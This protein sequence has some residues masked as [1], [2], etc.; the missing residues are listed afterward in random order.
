MRLYLQKF[1]SAQQGKT[2]LDQ[3]IQ[4]MPDGN[5]RI[6]IRKARN[7]KS[8]EQRGWLW[9][10]IYPVLLDAMVDAG[11]EI[12]TI[13]E[14]HEFFKKLFASHKVINRFTGE[15]I[16]IPDST[17]EMDTSEYSAYCEKLRE[18]AWE[19]LNVEIPDPDRNWKLTDR[20]NKTLVGKKV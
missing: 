10:H 12:T 5:Y 16:E 9:N 18:Y 1:G 15:I 4:D 20:K 8:K 2:Y 17:A 7:P 6:D 3:Y 11:W 13:D 19:F 14:V